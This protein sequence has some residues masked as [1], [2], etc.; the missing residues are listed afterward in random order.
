[1][2]HLVSMGEL[3]IDF[4]PHQKNV[5]LKE[6]HTFTK[7]AGGAPANVAACYAKLSGKAYFMGQIGHDPF[8]QFLEKSLRD[9]LVDTT[10]LSM[11]H[12]AKTALAFV[13]LDEQG[14]RDFLFYRN[15]S[16]DQLFSPKQVKRD[17]L[18]H[19][20]LHFGSVGLKE[21]PLKYAHLEA[22]KYAKKAASIISFDPN[23][24][25]PLWENHEELRHIV[26]SIIPEV[27]ILKLS[28]DEL[29]FLAQT[30]HIEQAIAKVF[31]GAV[32]MILLTKGNQG[33]TLYLK[34]HI[35]HVDAFKVDTVDSTGAGDAFLGAFLY[36][37]ALHE[38]YSIDYDFILR[39]AA[40][41]AAIVVTRYGAIPSLPTISE[42]H[43][44]LSK[45][46][47]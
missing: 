38:H 36:Q 46:Q 44:F 32:Q 14:D 25:L 8:G 33:A 35:Y 20:I 41:T 45:S 47:G 3:L 43:Q 34:N 11:T 22:M 17:I 5:G 18:N 10:Y 29:I 2:R 1:M 6:V 31:K 9:A 28:L 37:Y 4:I 15:P 30:H 16:A 12:E 23:I 26:L 27:H 39:F 42:V 19:A 40:A 13:T 24:R 21:Y 7:M